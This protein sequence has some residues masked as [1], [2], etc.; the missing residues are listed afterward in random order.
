MASIGSERSTVSIGSVLRLDKSSSI[1]FGLLSQP[2]IKTITH[3]GSKAIFRGRDGVR[4]FIFNTA[5]G[6]WGYELH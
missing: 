6:W 5:V 4:F 3:K 1:T 2:P